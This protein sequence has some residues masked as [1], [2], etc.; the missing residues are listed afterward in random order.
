LTQRFFSDRADDARGN[1]GRPGGRVRDH[2]L[3][4]LVRKV[5]LRADAAGRC[6]KRQS[7]TDGG[8]ARHH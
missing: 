3:H 8:D 4:G 5:L 7:C 6:G 2:E 1:I